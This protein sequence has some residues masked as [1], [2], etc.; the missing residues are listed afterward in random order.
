MTYALLGSRFQTDRPVPSKRF[1]LLRNFSII[2]LS[3]FTIAICLLSSFYRQQAE[4]DLLISTEENNAA[5]TQ[6]LSNTIWPKYDRFLFSIRALGDEYLLSNSTAKSI[7][8]DIRTQVK[9]TTI[10]KVKVFDYNGRV[11]F[12]TEAAQVGSKKGRSP[13]FL[14]AKS[15]QIVSQIDHRDTFQ[16]LDSTLV[17]RHLLSSYVPS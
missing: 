9:G 7:G 14:A 3:G 6:V 11:V 16:S 8:E 15:G 12:S 10:E 2:S 5:L 17:N 13:E 1:R 4:R